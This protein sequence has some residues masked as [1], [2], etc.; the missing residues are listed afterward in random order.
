MSAIA[1]QAGWIG[2]AG[3]LGRRRVASLETRLGRRRLAWR[4]ALAACAALVLV[5]A[6][7]W[8]RLQVVD[9]GYELSTARSVEQRLIQ[10]HR[11]LLLELATVTAPRRLEEQ[12]RLRLGMQDPAP[13][14]IVTLR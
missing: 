13:G 1:A 5:L 11:E 12:A 8:V 10:Q 6:L 3:A 2:R 14:Q 7:V 4:A 9:T